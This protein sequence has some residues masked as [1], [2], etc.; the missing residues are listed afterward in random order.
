[1]WINNGTEL[2]MEKL[3]VDVKGVFPEWY[4]THALSTDITFKQMGFE[5][6]FTEHEKSL[7][8]V[9]ELSSGSI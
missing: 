7:T 5:V 3:T 6:G 2:H 9:S 1:M 8:L 4:T